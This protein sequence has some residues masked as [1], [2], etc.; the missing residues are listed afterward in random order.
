MRF[1]HHVFICANQKGEG[2]ACCGEER[3]MELVMKFRD[4][5]AE[6]GLKGKV[7]AQRSACLDACQRGPVLVVYPDGTYY[8]HVKPEDVERIVD[9]HL[10]QGKPVED[11]LLTFP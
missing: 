2:K 4:V 3:G 11:L 9:S 7:R 1:E 8:G 5:L 10:I 6:K